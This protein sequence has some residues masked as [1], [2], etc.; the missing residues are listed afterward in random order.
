MATSLISY[1]WLPMLCNIQLLLMT[2]YKEELLGNLENKKK[3]V[4]QE[5]ILVITKDYYI[6]K[7][8]ERYISYSKHPKP[9]KISLFFKMEVKECIVL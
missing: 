2:G 6:I 7:G 5:E 1:P 3:F 9:K 4:S 8:R